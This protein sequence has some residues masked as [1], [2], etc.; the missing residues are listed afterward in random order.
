MNK[1]EVSD[2]L[3]TKI[4]PALKSYFDYVESLT[5]EDMEDV[6]SDDLDLDLTDTGINPYQL[7][8]VLK[9]DFGYEYEDMDRNG[10]EMDF[11]IY[12][13]RKD[14]KSFPSGCQRMIIFGIGMTFSLG[15]TVQD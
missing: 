2:E 7:R 6:T 11:W 5:D 9:S 4:I 10:W 1:W 13:N 3:K 12:M 15:L 8:E 14:G